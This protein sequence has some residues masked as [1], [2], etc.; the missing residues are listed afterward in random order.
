MTVTVCVMAVFYHMGTRP[1]VHVRGIR[2]IW[3]DVDPRCST[4]SALRPIA[5]R[6][7]L[8]CRSNRAGQCSSHGTRVE[9][10]EFLRAS[11]RH[12]RSWAKAA[13]QFVITVIGWA[14]SPAV[15][16]MTCCPLRVTANTLP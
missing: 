7:R 1:S 14:V 16:T 3:I 6:M 4:N 5:S 12:Y 9:I 8:A 15:L 10:A 11:G 13:V 2:T